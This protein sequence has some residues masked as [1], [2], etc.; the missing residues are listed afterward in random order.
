MEVIKR[1]Q[2]QRITV[3]RA[4]RAQ[5]A[6]EALHSGQTGT[7]EKTASEFTV[8][9]KLLHRFTDC[10]ANAN[11]NTLKSPFYSIGVHFKYHSP[12]EIHVTH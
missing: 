5:E 12:T 7:E 10:D 2:E 1:L 8:L 3:A 9:S 11:G 4:K 6:D